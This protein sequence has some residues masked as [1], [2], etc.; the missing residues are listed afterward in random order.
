MSLQ[1]NADTG[2]LRLERFMTTARLVLLMNYLRSS[3]TLRFPGVLAA[4]FVPRRHSHAKKLLLTVRMYN[5][6]PACNPTK[7]RRIALDA[8][9]RYVSFDPSAAV[10]S[11]GFGAA[12]CFRAPDAFALPALAGLAPDLPA[13]TPV[14]FGASTM[15]S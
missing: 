10:S 5:P 15:I 11:A 13:G 1:F 14:F 7:H 3:N 12:A 8:I 9:G 4:Y 6:Q 2:W